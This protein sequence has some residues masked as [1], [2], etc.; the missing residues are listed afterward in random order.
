VHL[1]RSEKFILID[2]HSKLTSEV[3]YLPADSPTDAPRVIAPRRQGVEYSVEHHGH[4]FLILHNDGA[5][6]VALAYTSV[7][8]P[9]AWTPL[10]EHTPGT[11]LLQV[12]AFTGHLVVSLRRDG[13][14]G[15]RVLRLD[16]GR[17]Y[18]ITFPEP[19]YTVE[20]MFTPEYETT[21]LRLGYASLVTPDSVY[22][23]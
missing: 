19:L 3:H 11:R 10:I 23:C 20:P 21:T 14:T 17:E 6:D 12:D 18:D 15:L 5:E 13:L 22:D 9:G 16:G 1:S 4:R 7:D 8:A 2:I